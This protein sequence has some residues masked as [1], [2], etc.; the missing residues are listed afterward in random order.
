MKI[1]AALPILF[2]ALQAGFEVVAADREVLVVSSGSEAD[3]P[4]VL[5]IYDF[6]TRTWRSEN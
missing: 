1:F 2:A 6:L 4:G 5:E 3:Q